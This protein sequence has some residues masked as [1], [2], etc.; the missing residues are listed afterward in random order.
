MASTWSFTSESPEETRTW[1]TTLADRLKPGDVVLLDGDLGSGK[2]TL[3]QGL[4]GG[5]GV[6][7]WVN[8]PTFT[9]INE[10]TGRLKVHHCDFYRLADP[11]ELEALAVEEVFY[12]DGVALVEW[13]DVAD[14]WVP[15]DAVRITITRT[16][17]EQRRFEV[18]GLNRVDG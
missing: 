14:G 13:P 1:G 16:G 9:L 10:Y 17:A 4:C 15:P 3:A 8:S 5:L 7:E 2:T 12:G 11:S 6:A 18:K